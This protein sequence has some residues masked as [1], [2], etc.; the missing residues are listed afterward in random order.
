MLNINKLPLSVAVFLASDQYDYDSRDKVISATSILR[1][2][3][4]TIMGYRAAK[5]GIVED[6]D[7]TDV[8]ASRDGTALHDAIEAVWGDATLRYRALT[9]LGYDSNFIDRIVVNPTQVVNGQIPIYMENREERELEGHII[10]GKYDIIFDGQVEDYKKTSAF[11]VIKTLD[12]LAKYVPLTEE[13][14]PTAWEYAMQGSIYKWLNPTK[15]FD[16]YMRINF[17]I[18]DYN[19]QAKARVSTNPFSVLIPLFDTVQTEKFLVQRIKDLQ[20]QSALKQSDITPCT[21][22]QLWMDKPKY[23]YY[24]NPSKTTGRSTRTF[25][26]QKEAAIH[27]AKVAPKGVWVTDRG[28]ARAC[29]YCRGR[30]ICKQYKQLHKEGKV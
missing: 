18:R 16:P 8:L 7:V 5:E 19:L 24:A 15:I 12:D 25:T 14:T 4:K 3:K 9:K 30:P 21:P 6:L 17:F 10:T 27:K 26:C 1:P 11:K 28:K 2:V 13:Y 29:A 20:K 22:Q 23:K